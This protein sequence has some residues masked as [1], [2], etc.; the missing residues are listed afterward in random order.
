MFLTDIFLHFE[1]YLTKWSYLIICNSYFWVAFC[2]DLAVY[3]V[4]VLSLKN[5]HHIGIFGFRRF[6]E[7]VKKTQKINL[8][9]LS[10]T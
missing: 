5:C 7:K 4:Q 9:N 1:Y 8:K 3:V 10:K 6:E 2:L